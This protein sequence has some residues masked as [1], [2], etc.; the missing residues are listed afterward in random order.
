MLKDAFARLSLASGQTCSAVGLGAIGFDFEFPVQAMGTDITGQP[1]FCGTM[2]GCEF[3]FD[4]G[5][6]VTA[7]AIRN[8]T[9]GSGEL[10]VGISGYLEDVPAPTP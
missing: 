1:S 3:V 8:T 9:G 2:N 6:T 4:S 7:G 5:N 10:T